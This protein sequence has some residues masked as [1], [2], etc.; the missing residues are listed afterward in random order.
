MKLSLALVSVLGLISSTAFAQQGI[1]LGIPG[2]AGT[3]CP[4]N[5]VS[6]VLSPDATQLSVL[7]DTF[8]MEAG[9]M[10]G[11]TIDRKNCSVAIP[12]NVPQGYQV[13]LVSID[14]RGFNALPGGATSRFSSEYFFAGSRGPT[15]RQDFRGPLNQD[16]TLNNSLLVSSLVWSSCGAQ[17]I[18]R[19]N[20]SMQTMTN[21]RR[22]QALSTID[23][24]D[25][26]SGLIYSLQ[27]RRCI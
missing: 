23:S 4:A 22:D 17:A 7:F 21:S 6:A 11:R 1:T 25:V 14:Y 5:S 9:G 20:I 26:D 12:V 2:Y 10:T 24:M 8:T 3:G 18:L 27:W 15:F 16:Y 19:S 13:S